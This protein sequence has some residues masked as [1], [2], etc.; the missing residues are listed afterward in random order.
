M[1]LELKRA[2]SPSSLGIIVPAHEPTSQTR[3]LD[4]NSCPE[5]SSLL[6]ILIYLYFKTLTFYRRDKTFENCNMS[7]VC[8]QSK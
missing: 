7:N 1:K 5:S 4:R 6:T 2:A 3:C 8:G